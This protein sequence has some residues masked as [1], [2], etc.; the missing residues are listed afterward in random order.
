M[1][2][3]LALRRVAIRRDQHGLGRD[4]IEFFGRV[5]RI[6]HGDGD[7]GDAAHQE[8]VQLAPLARRSA[9]VGDD[10]LDIVIRVLVL[11]FSSPR[12]A[13]VEKSAA[14][15]VTNA[16]VFS[17]PAPPPWPSRAQL[18]PRSAA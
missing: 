16:M 13:M 5:R 11:R 9:H 14:T 10:Q 1:G 7:A 8:V 18:R 6:I 12:P 3:A 17:A 2:E 15:L 4:L